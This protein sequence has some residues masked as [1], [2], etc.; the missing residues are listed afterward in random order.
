MEDFYS[1][2]FMHKNRG[3][4]GGGGGEAERIYSDDFLFARKRI[5]LVIRLLIIKWQRKVIKNTI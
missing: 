2:S 5:N 3:V 1:E 4:E